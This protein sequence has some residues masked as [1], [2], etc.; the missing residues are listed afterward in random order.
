MVVLK[1]ETAPVPLPSRQLKKVSAHVLKYV[2]T[3]V[4]FIRLEFRVLSI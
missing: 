3:G 2:M 4:L 1:H